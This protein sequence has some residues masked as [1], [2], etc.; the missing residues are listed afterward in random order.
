MVNFICTIGSSKSC[1]MLNTLTVSKFL[2][3]KPI[4]FSKS[5]NF[6]CTHVVYQ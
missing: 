2:F 6:H 5:L 4:P 1:M 3:A